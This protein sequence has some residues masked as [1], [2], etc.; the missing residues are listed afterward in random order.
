MSG[1]TLPDL[2]DMNSSLLIAISVIALISFAAARSG[3][4]RRIV[5]LV[6]WLGGIA[7]L[8]IV[9]AEQGRFHPAIAAMLDRLNLDP[10]HIVGGEVRVPLS[11]DGHFWV[12]ANMG[13]VERRMLFDTGA[14]VTALSPDTAAS[15]GAVL[16]TGVTP[17]ITQTANG[18]IVAR[19]AT[20]SRL[21]IGTIEARNL[22][23]VVSPGLGRVDILGMNFLMRLKC[24]RVEDRTLILTPETSERPPNPRR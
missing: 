1:M 10:Q 7:V 12:R 23:V 13:G 8:T 19:A 17:V 16:R 14:T 22:P 11:T 15:A 21:T 3:V 5:S 24:W 18:S 6:F 20:V 2:P 4:V 9:V